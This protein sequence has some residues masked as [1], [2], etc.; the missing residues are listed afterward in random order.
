[1]LCRVSLNRHQL[2]SRYSCNGVEE[3]TLQNKFQYF[4]PALRKLDSMN[5]IVS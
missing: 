1:M 4:S 3:R 5:L 2:K